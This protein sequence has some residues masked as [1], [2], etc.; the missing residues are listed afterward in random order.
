MIG[1]LAIAVGLLLSSASAEA[2][3]WPVRPIRLIVPY[4]AGGGTDIVARVLGQK[5]ADALGQVFIVENKSGA[6]GMIAAQ[7]VAKGSTDGYTFLVGT[8]N[9]I[10]INQHLLADI[11]YNPLTDLTP[12]TLLAWTPLVL[13]AHPSMQASTPSELIALARARS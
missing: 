11:G 4:P 3:D 12:V 5:L 7:A 10:V 8:P 13:A 9:E 2:Q 1:R 6:T